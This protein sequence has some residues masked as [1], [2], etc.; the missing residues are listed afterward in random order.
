MGGGIDETVIGT[1]WEEEVE[2]KSRCEES[3]ISFDF[4]SNCIFACQCIPKSM[5]LLQSLHFDLSIPCY[6]IYGCI[7]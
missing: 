7:E 5:S 3:D 4:P 2:Y 1:V 6:G